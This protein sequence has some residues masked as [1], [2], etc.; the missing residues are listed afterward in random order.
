M[1]SR[2]EQILQQ[3]KRVRSRKGRRA[4]PEV[5]DY[6]EVI[7]ALE[8]VRG[9]ATSKDVARHL[10]V[11]PSAVTKMLRRLR[12]L[13]YIDYEQY[14]GFVLTETGREVAADVLRRHEVLVRFL[15]KLGVPPETAEEEAEFIE[16]GLS[17]S[18][19]EILSALIDFLESRPDVTDELIRT[20]E[21]KVR[22]RSSANPVR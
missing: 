19:L 2:E 17:S 9:F 16:H 12:Q 10:N 15:E 6:L 13:G 5:E 14:R 22:Q 8:K 4:M 11:R 3:V 20:I 18:T 1:A 21:E 7:Y